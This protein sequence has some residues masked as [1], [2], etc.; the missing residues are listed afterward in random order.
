MER[1]LRAVALAAALAAFGSSPAAATELV[2]DN[3]AQCP[4]AAHTSIQAGVDAAA[5]G[6]RVLVCNGV[7]QEAVTI[8]GPAK[9]GVDL[10]ANATL[11]ASIKPPPGYFGPIVDIDGADRVQVRRFRI[12]GPFGP[13]CPSNAAGSM[14]GVMVRGRA[15]SA[16]I[17]LNAISSIGDPPGP[18]CSETFGG[19]GVDFQWG[20]GVVGENTIEGYDSVGVAVLGPSFVNM[21]NNRVV[22]GQTPNRFETG[23]AVQDAELRAVDNVIAQNAT[24][25]DLLGNALFGTEVRQVALQHNRVTEGDVGI[26]LDEQKKADISGNIV[27][28]NAEQGILTDPAGS[29]NNYLVRNDFRGNG[30]N[31][32]E[33][34]SAGVFPSQPGS[35]RYTTQNFWFNNKGL[36]ASPAPICTPT[37]ATGPPVQ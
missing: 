37:G 21:I 2:D 11:G 4:S 35:P 36:D 27:T 29:F 20:R 25:I 16:N 33:D 1:A 6:E 32:C 14:E 10:V 23:L 17:R 8:A 22:A 26:R 5:P 24:G 13:T 31:D 19:T 18:D 28:A 7:Y 30:G 15:L 12:A 3:K 34:Q 9:D